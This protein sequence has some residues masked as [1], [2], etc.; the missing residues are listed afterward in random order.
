[1]AGH[2]SVKKRQKELL[3]KERREEKASKRDQR[4]ADRNSA[5]ERALDEFGNVVEEEALPEE[6]VDGPPRDQDQVEA[7][8]VVPE[9]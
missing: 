8:A 4:R 2:P 6:A 9:P 3:R 5:P 7:P 1:M